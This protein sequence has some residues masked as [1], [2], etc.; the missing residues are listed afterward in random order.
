MVIDLY[1][2]D[3]VSVDF[4]VVKTAGIAAVILKATLGSGFVNPTFAPRVADARAAGM[5][6]RAYH[7]MDGTSPVERIAHFLSVVGNTEN[8]L[9]A[10]DF[11]A[12]EVS[13]ARVTQVAYAIN[14]VKAITRR[15]PVI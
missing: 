1:H 11:E 4:S 3:K 14:A 2:G 8:V 10:L 5:L 6:V 12:D 9:L 7:F 13:Q 15:F